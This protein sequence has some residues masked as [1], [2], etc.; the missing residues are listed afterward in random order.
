VRVPLVPA[1]LALIPLFSSWIVSV[2]AV[3]LV[4][5]RLG[6]LSSDEKFWFSFEFLWGRSCDLFVFSIW[7][8]GF[9]ALFLIGIGFP[10]RSCF[11]AGISLVL[12]LQDPKWS[13]GLYGVD[14]LNPILQH[15]HFRVACIRLRYDW[16]QS[17]LPEFDSMEVISCLGASDF[18]KNLLLIFCELRCRQRFPFHWVFLERGSGNQE[19]FG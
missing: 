12:C 11:C 9:S 6:G 2:P 13:G 4:R 17:E 16:A 3:Y 19:L 8:G 18:A 10:L 5:L 15:L 1:R 7:F 14:Y